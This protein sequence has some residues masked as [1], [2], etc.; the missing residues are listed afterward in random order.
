MALAFPAELARWPLAYESKI[1]RFVRRLYETLSSA[2]LIN[3]RRNRSR[4]R[5]INAFLDSAFQLH[6]NDVH[7]SPVHPTSAGSQWARSRY[8]RALAP[9]H[10]IARPDPLDFCPNSDI[11]DLYFSTITDRSS[12]L[13]HDILVQPVSTKYREPSYEVRDTLVQ[14]MARIRS[15]ITAPSSLARH[16]YLWLPPGNLT[17]LTRRVGAVA[18]DSTSWYIVVPLITI[19]R[20][21]DSIVF[22]PL[23]TLTVFFLST[24]ETFDRKR[25][26]SPDELNQ[27]M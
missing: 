21:A 24:N 27:L 22:R 20:K 8:N 25:S 3:G 12:S 6:R 26:V 17:L 9:F 10:D 14:L 18:D 1:P 23:I 5:K 13:G 4:E 16:Y 2:E 19:S 15:T 11:T 7:L